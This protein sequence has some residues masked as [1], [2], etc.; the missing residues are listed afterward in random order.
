[1]LQRKQQGK[2][3]DFKFS[4]KLQHIF[5][6]KDVFRIYYV[7]IKSNI[8][9]HVAMKSM[10]HTRPGKM[11]KQKLQAIVGAE[12]RNVPQ[13]NWPNYDIE[14]A[15]YVDAIVEQP[16]QFEVLTAKL[17]QRIQR[18]KTADLSHIPPALLRY[19]GETMQEYLNRCYD[20]AGYVG[21]L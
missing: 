12:R 14:T 9:T 3:I 11:V 2:N 1:M 15:D 13:C 20:A 6:N 8:N 21:G 5:S 19:E 16:E 18:Y 4:F 10:L 17:W 7:S